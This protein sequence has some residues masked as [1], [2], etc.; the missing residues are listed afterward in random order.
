MVDHDFRDKSDENAIALTDIDNWFERLI[1]EEEAA[2]NL[3]KEG[4]SY[5][6]ALSLIKKYGLSNLGREKDHD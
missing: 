6:E 1:E 5:L 4:Y 3:G 2:D